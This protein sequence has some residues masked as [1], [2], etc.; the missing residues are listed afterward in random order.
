MYLLSSAHLSLSL[1][2]SF[3]SSRLL[4]FVS[5]TLLPLSA[6]SHDDHNPH[7]QVNLTGFV[8]DTTRTLIK[9]GA[10]AAAAGTVAAFISSR[11]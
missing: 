6:P 7:S 11:M 10:G 2:L 5:P 8:S 4:Y 9:F 3:F 1:S